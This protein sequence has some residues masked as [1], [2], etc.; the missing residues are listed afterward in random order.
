MRSCGWRGREKQRLR[1]MGRQMVC[2]VN[3]TY[4]GKRIFHH[5]T[6][7]ERACRGSYDRIEWDFDAF[8]LSCYRSM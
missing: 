2:E 7:G 6:F 8:A 3:G 5:D 4:Q 1:R